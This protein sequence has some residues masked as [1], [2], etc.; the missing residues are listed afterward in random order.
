MTLSGL[1]AQDPEAQV[2]LRRALGEPN[3]I[4]PEPGDLVLLCAQRVSL[5]VCK[6][7]R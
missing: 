1:S 7:R 2:G 5:W 4:L 6:C 3:V